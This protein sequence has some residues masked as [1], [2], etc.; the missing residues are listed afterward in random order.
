[1]S[2][3][4]ALESF[5]Q[6]TE[7]I[8]LTKNGKEKLEKATV[9]SIQAVRC[10]TED[11][12]TEIKLGVGDRGLFRAGWNSLRLPTELPEPLKTDT[13]DAVVDHSNRVSSTGLPTGTDV[14]V[15]VYSIADVAKFLGQ[16][17]SESSVQVPTSQGA[18]AGASGSSFMVDSSRLGTHTSARAAS[19]V[20][21]KTLAKDSLLNR[22]AGQFAQG[23]LQDTLSLQELSLAGLV[24]G[25]KAL[26]PVNFVTVFTGCGAEDEEVLG[27]GQNQ[28]R[29]V[30]QSGKAGAL[31]KPTA[32]RMSYGQFFEA[33]ARILNL[34]NLDEQS[35][36]EYLD[37][38]R[39]LG[40]LLQ[41]F[42]VASVF[43]L[44]HI[45]RQFV[46]ESGGRWNFIEN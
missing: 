26:L 9:C 34:L 44:D 10:L 23:G 22:L 25:D 17:R 42:T 2:E 1:M 15:K 3:G 46:H 18:V 36:T 43:T 41:T 11:D 32:D 6:W 40:I 19:N 38:L 33:N 28:G 12:I 4:D 31:K 20:T 24:K 37:Y 13:A 35:Y 5:E 14:D 27:C 45:H 29:L 39:Q 21:A 16:N 7:Y 30:W 8:G